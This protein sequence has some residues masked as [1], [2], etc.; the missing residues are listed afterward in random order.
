MQNDPN[1]K[2]KFKVQ[3]LI[4]PCLQVVDLLLPSHQENAHGPVLSRKLAIELGSL[5][6]SEDKAFIQAMLLNRHMPLGSEHLFKLVNWSTLLPERFKKNHVYMEPVVGNWSYPDLLSYK[7]SPMIASDSQLLNL[8][9]TYI[10]TCQHDVIRDDGFMYASRLRS[11]GLNVS[12]DHM[13]DGVHAA[14]SFARFPLYLRLGM[15]IQDKYI[16]WLKENL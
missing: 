13:E 7:T 4:Y 14:I 10:L 16:R 15:R 5:H 2:T 11:L 8:P 12:H 6:V 3:A 1:F 9:Q